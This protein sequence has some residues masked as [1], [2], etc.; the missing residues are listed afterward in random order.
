MKGRN[1][2]EHQKGKKPVLTPKENRQQKREKSREKE[3]TVGDRVKEQ[4]GR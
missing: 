2:P 1:K 3:K 4:F